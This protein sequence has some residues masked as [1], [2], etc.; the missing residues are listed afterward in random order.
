MHGIA[1]IG[2]GNVGRIRALEIQRSRNSRVVTVADTDLGRAEDLAKAVGAEA[3]TDWRRSLA[4][5]GID[6]AVVSTPTK[7]HTQAVI[8]ALRNG[9][10]GRSDGSH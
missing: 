5:S 6:A 4:G 9:K 3:V 1:I 8:T 10:H 7:F 2:A